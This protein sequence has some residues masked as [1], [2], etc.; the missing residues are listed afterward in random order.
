[1]IA[2]ENLTDQRDVLVTEHGIPTALRVGDGPEFIRLYSSDK[3]FADGLLRWTSGLSRQG[4]P[5]GTDSSNPS[6]V[7]DGTNVPVSTTFT[8]AAMRKASSVCG[9]RITAR[10][11]PFI[12]GCLASVVYTEECTHKKPVAIL[13]ETKPK[14]GDMSPASCC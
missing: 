11:A 6:K 13:A 9:R 10:P 12:P 1:L 5:G 14:T 4:N 3:S 2:A 7:G 8:L